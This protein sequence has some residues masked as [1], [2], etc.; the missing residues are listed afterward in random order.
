MADAPNGARQTLSMKIVLHRKPQGIAM[1]IVM[2]SL[3]VLAA[4]AGLFAFHMQVETKLAMNSNNSGDLECLGRSGIEVARWVLS[5][6]M[7]T[8]NTPF[9]SLNQVWAGGPGETND[10]LAG[11]SMENIQ[12][13]EGK[14]RKITITD[15]ERKFNINQVLR[16]P[17]LMQHALIVIGVDASVVPTIVA[18]TQDWID[19]DDDTHINGAESEVYQAKD[20]PYRAKNGP[21]DDI[22]ELLYIHEITSDMYSS[23]TAPSVLQSTK[24]TT[25]SGLL[26]TASSASVGLADIFTPISSGKINLNTASATVLQMIPGLDENS[27]NEI[28]RA[29]DEVAAFRS[30]GEATMNTSLGRNMTPMLQ[31][32]CTVRS[33]TFEIQ[34]DVEIGQSQ[35]RYFAVVVR[36]SPTD[37]Q[38]LN[39]HWE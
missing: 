11:F 22:S 16:N 14:I 9:D 33:S 18:S 5:Q 2:V 36:N 39:M 24:N 15:A 10:P 29:R 38:I 27:A 23:N 8:P 30:V 1:V 19:K 26:P 21:I 3:F 12:V 32:Y 37:I 34:V 7:K 28:V 25:R 4:M 17:D 31:Q 35:R 13:G 20:P 6:E